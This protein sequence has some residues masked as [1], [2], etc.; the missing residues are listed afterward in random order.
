KNITRKVSK[1]ILLIITFFVI[2]NFVI[3]GLSVAKASESAKTLTRQKMRAVVTYAVDYDKFWQVGDQIEDE[4]ER[5]EFYKHYPNI[6]LGDVKSIIKDERVKTANALSTN[7]WYTA[8]DGLDYVHL[9]NQAEQDNVG[10]ESCYLDYDTKEEICE[11]YKNPTFMVKS[12]YL[13][14]MIEFADGDWTIAQGNFYTQEQIDSSATV[15]LI[16]SALA[17]TNNINV[18][19]TITLAQGYQSSWNKDMGIEDEEYIVEL[20][21]IGIYDHNNPVTPGASNYDWLSPY[22]NPDNMILMP[23]STMNALNYPIAIKQWDYYKEQYPDDDYYQDE[24]NYPKLEQNDKQALGDA[25][26]LLNDPLEVD[27]FVKEYKDTLS[28]YHK[29]NVNNEEFKK[30]SKPLDTLSDY[31][32]FIVGLVVVNAIVIITLVTALTL[33]TR[34]Y[35][36]GVLLSIGASKLKVVLQFFVELAIVALIGFTLAVGSGSIISKRVGTTLLDNQ[37]QSSGL[38]EEEEYQYTTDYY[39]PWN[40]NYDTEISLDDIIAEYDVTVS[41][42]IIGEIYVVGLGIVLISVVIPSIMIMRFN[43]K[44]ILM[45]QG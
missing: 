40:N 45:N 42:F 3:I 25:I 34:E 19:D 30:L 32:E 24:E 26:I 7:A 37:I 4:D 29:L 13:P 5:N 35:E 22:E 6:T 43:P 44:K 18:G 15:C 8:E 20:E 21:V 9:N 11:V 27:N 36:I 17:E 33:K 16:T 10:G 1:S 31:A 41:P 28:E 14:N 2:G 39:D 12:N 23:A 38:N